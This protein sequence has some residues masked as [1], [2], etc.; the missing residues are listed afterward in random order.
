MLV[1][2]FNND[3]RYR[4]EKAQQEALEQA[5]M[6]AKSA[7]RAKTTFL[8][9]MSHDIRTPMN[10]IIGYTGLASTHI[11]NKNQV[12]DYLGKIT[13]SS[14]HLLSLINDVLDMSRIEAGK[15]IIHKI[16]S[17]FRLKLNILLLLVDLNSSWFS[18]FFCASSKKS[19]MDEYLLPR[20][21]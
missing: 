14:N 10:A 15:I 8:N 9:N 4:R 17:L 21:T 16:N 7:S 12:K 13:Q 20:S 3:A 5:L 18:G 2:I 6:M 11:D 1:G 19:R